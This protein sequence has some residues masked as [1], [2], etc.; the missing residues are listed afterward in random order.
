ME[1]MKQVMLKTHVCKIKGNPPWRANNQAL[2][3]NQKHLADKLGLTAFQLFLQNQQ[4][5]TLF[6]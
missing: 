6:V 4:F 3:Y 1:K 2:K 5:E